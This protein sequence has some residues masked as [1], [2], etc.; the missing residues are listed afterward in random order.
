MSVYHE[1]LR[2]GRITRHSFGG[3][4]LRRQ[5]KDAKRLE[6]EERNARTPYERTKRARREAANHG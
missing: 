1:A 2:S 3:L 6:A 5:L 4:A